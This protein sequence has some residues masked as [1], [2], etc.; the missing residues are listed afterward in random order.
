MCNN[1]VTRL[2]TKDMDLNQAFHAL[3]D[4]ARRELIITLSKGPQTAGALAAP[5]N[6][7]RPAISRHL[8]VLRDAEL[9]K[10]QVIGRQHWYHLQTEAIDD[11]QQWLE[12]VSSVWQEGLQALKAFVEEGK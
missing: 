2:F 10:V 7:S 6:I 9:V 11:M 1:I 8:R 3:S 5:Y 12:E 4:P